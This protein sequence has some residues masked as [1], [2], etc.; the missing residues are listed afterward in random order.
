MVF[1]FRDKSISGTIILLLLLIA[2]H[3]HFFIT[4]PVIITNE[5]DGF[6]SLFIQKFITPLNTTLIYILYILVV[7][8]QALRLNLAL[9]NF[10]MFQQQHQTVALSYILFTAFFIEWSYF[11]SALI[12]NFFIIWVFIK[13]AALHNNPNPKTLLFN[14]GLITGIAILGYHSIYIIVIAL[15]LVL[16]IIR[17]FRLAEWLLMLIGIIV[18]FYFLAAWLYLTDQFHVFYNY[19]PD[20]YIH[21]PIKHLSI[22]MWFSIGLIC[23]LALLGIYYNNISN[24]R[25]VIQIRKSWGVIMI[26]LMLL[27]PVPFIFKHTTLDAAILC[28]V[29]LS[30]ITANVYSNTKRLLLPNI[31]FWLSIVIIIYNNWLLFKS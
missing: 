25:M 12:A 28:I 10:K 19:I 4:P 5:H 21:L 22:W 11:S 27:L 7:F 3:I 29:P 30:A 14:T 15:L 20:F 9:N 1:L 18:P 31:L 26:L 2:I 8:V 16:I 24:K 13:L 17:P 23:L 6:I